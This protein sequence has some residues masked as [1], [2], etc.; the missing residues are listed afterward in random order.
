[1]TCLINSEY[2]YVNLHIQSGR[3]F[4]GKRCHNTAPSS[5]TQTFPTVLLCLAAI[6]FLNFLHGFTVSQPSFMPHLIYSHCGR[7]QKAHLKLFL[8]LRP[9]TH[10]HMPFFFYLSLSVPSPFTSFSLSV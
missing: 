10:H 1:M 3:S 6:S 5:P 9:S 2:L 4:S 7:S 8:I